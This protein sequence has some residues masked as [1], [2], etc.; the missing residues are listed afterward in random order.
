MHHHGLIKLRD[1]AIINESTASPDYEFLKID[2]SRTHRINFCH[3]AYPPGD[4]ILFTLSAFDHPEGGIHHGF[5]LSVCAIVADNCEGG[6]LSLTREGGPIEAG[7]DDVLP[8]GHDYFYHVPYPN[9]AENHDDRNPTKPY[10][11]PAVTNFQDWK[12]PHRMPEVWTRC[13]SSMP[14]ILPSGTASQSNYTLAVRTRDVSCRITQHYTGTEVAH[15]CPESER[16]W[17]ISNNMQQYKTNLNSDSAHLL[18]DPGNMLLIRSDLHKPFDDRLFIFFPKGSEG[19]LVVH[20]LQQ[21]PDLSQ[22]YHN[23][24]IH[25]VPHCCP[26]FLFARFAWSVFPLLGGFLSRRAPRFVVTVNAETGERTPKEISDLRPLQAKAATSRSRSP[27]KRPRQAEDADELASVSEDDRPTKRRKGAVCDD[28]SSCSGI[29]TP[30]PPSHSPQRHSKGFEW[31]PG[32]AALEALRQQAIVAQRPSNYLIE[33]EHGE[34]VQGSYWKTSLS[35]ELE[36][37]GFEIIGDY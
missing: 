1:P 11:W 35:K 8:T 28:S 31:Y 6:F 37:I 13:N 33:V 16:D 3:P 20:M 12:F 24:E 30:P 9:D 36:D 27:Q 5:A 14:Q 4:E 26:E 7:L 34:E 2:V 25:P 18:K 21:T 29:D 32:S 22:L 17:F 23:V 19:S 10:K 15:L